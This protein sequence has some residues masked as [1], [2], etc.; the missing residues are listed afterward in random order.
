MKVQELAPQFIT[1]GQQH[2]AYNRQQHQEQ[3]K[4]RGEFEPNLF[5]GAVL[6]LPTPY[7][8]AK[9]SRL[10]GLISNCFPSEFFFLDI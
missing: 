4:T 8:S 6:L 9:Q 5:E 7:R 2:E 10:C 3:N 1:H